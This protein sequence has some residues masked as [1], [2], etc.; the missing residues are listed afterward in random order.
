MNQILKLILLK[1]LDSHQFSI[2]NVISIAFMAIPEGFLFCKSGRG[3][4][5]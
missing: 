5:Q 4:S 2:D 3:V 1:E